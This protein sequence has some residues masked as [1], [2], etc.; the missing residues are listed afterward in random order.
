[1]LLPKDLPYEYHGFIGDAFF[2]K[3]KKGNFWELKTPSNC[4]EGWRG[5]LAKRSISLQHITHLIGNGMNTSFWL[6][7]WLPYG[8]LV[9]VYSHRTIYDLHLGSNI[10]VSHF[11]SNGGWNFPT[12]TSHALMEF[13]QIISSN[14]QH[15]PEFEDEIMWNPSELGRIT[16]SSSPS[17][18]N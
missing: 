13:F 10:S 14:G 4:S 6:D 18:S 8:H 9:D 16:T 1:M 12:T 17:I 2:F 11:I 5:I 3:K 15:F 7:L